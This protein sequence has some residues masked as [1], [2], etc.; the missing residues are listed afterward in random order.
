MPVYVAR[1]DRGVRPIGRWSTRTSRSNDSR[2][3][4]SSA[5]TWLTRVDLPEPD[6]PV[7]AVSTQRGMS[8]DTVGAGDGPG[9]APE[10]CDPAAVEHA[11]PGLARPR[12]DVDDPA[13]TPYD[14]KVV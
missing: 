12:P 5:S 11:A 10:P 7:T 4:G 2:T 3:A 1:L 8:T 13:R 9:A 14:V 6:T